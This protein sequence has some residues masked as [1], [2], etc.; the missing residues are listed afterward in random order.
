VIQ[1][2]LVGVVVPAFNEELLIGNV[3]ATM[4]DFVTHIIIVNDASTDATCDVARSADEAGRIKIVTHDVNLG[5]GQSLIDGYRMAESMGCDVV[6]VMAGDAQMSPGDLES[7]INPILENRADYV[8]G[9]R[10]LRPEVV[11][12]M[13]RYRLFGNALLT[14]LSK[15]A[16]GYWHSM[17]P[18]CGY[19]A[20]SGH[21][22][23]AIPLGKMVRGYGYNADLLNMLNVANLRVAEVE[24]EPVYGAE[25]SYIKLWRYVPLI[26]VLL[27]RLFARRILRKYV[28]TDFHP[29]ALMYG[30]T[31]FISVL[32][33]PPLT[34]RLLFLYASVGVIPTTTLLL[35]SFSSMFAFMSLFFAMWLDMEDNRRLWVESNPIRSYEP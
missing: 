25:T 13:P 17:D 33:L 14:F 7:V 21:A 23:S 32:I 10:L 26:S 24:V 35:L 22:L 19:T 12:R 6:A 30:F 11:D 18:Q 34:I 31:I 15:F 2:K 3:V 4:P 20:I 1:D 16:H 8:K 28:V 29:L 5:L 27:V 9:N